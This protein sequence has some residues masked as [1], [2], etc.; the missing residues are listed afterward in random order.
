MWV[1]RMIRTSVLV[2]AVLGAAV[3]PLAAQ[4]TSTASSSTYGVKG[5][6]VISTLDL[7]VPD[8]ILSPEQ[9][10]GV[11]AGGFVTRRLSDR[12]HLDVEA[13]V[14]TK[15]A[16]YN[17]GEDLE[18]LLKLTYLEVPI[19]ARASVFRGVYVSGGPYFA[20]KLK[21]VHEEDGQEVG[22]T[23]EAKKS[24]LGVAFGGG[25]VFGRWIVDARYS[26]GLVDVVDVDTGGF[27][28]PTA[29]TRALSLTVGYRF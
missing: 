16:S 13:L 1:C 18:N 21:E 6:V 11:T 26:L 2:T 5:G 3:T 28:E 27:A 15:S 23:G 24:D 10:I 22:I 4:T 17:L 12:L 20:I 25:A 14:T 7:V 29:K 19:V 8:F 9:Q